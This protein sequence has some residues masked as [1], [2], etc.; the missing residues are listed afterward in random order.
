M[1]YFD[2]KIFFCIPNSNFVLP[3]NY[4]F[5]LKL[6]QMC[7]FDIK[8]LHKKFYF[9]TSNYLYNSLGNNSKVTYTENGSIEKF[10]GKIRLKFPDFG[11]NCPKMTHLKYFQCP[12]YLIFKPKTN[13]MITDETIPLPPTIRMGSRRIFESKSGPKWLIWLKQPNKMSNFDLKYSRPINS[14]YRP[15]NH[16]YDSLD[17]ICY[18]TIYKNV[19][20]EEFSGQIRPNFADFGQNCSKMTHFD[21]KI[22]P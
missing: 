14:N 9:L 16:L 11:K 22:F 4:W 20:I 7:Y 12:K 6:P 18:A 13:S 1:P 8:I 21:L 3:E 15:L 2:P 10:W 5:W 19:F 17:N